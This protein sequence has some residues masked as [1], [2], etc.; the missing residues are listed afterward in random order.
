MLADEVNTA[1]KVLFCYVLHIHSSLMLELVTVRYM[2]SCI[3]VGFFFSLLVVISYACD[4]QISPF[5]PD[6]FFV[7]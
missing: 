4:V 3:Q 1:D 5:K 7:T 2:T 6:Y